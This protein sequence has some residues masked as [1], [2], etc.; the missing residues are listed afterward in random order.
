MKIVSIDNSTKDYWE[1]TYIEAFPPEERLPFEQLVKMTNDND[2]IHLS[3]IKKDEENVGILF[4]GE[5]SDT[6]AYVF[7]FAIDNKFRNGGY[8]TKILSMLKERFPDGI[9]LESEELGLADSDNEEQRLR[10]YNFYL[11]NG[12]KDSKHLMKIYDLSF[13]ILT[14]GS[15]DTFKKYQKFLNDIQP[16]AWF[17]EENN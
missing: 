7:F 11:R 4:H 13:H 6:E 12:F 10:R 9:I 8:G 1:K 2:H 5:L 16:E 3:I 14:T 17:T 15:E